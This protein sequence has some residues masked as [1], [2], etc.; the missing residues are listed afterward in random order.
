[1][2]FCADAGGDGATLPRRGYKFIAPVEKPLSQ[3]GK[4]PDPTHRQETQ[5]GKELLKRRAVAAA[6]AVLLLGGVGGAFHY[7]QPRLPTVTN[8]VRITNDGKAKITTNSPATDGVRLY[9]VEGEP[10]TTG[11]G[12]A[13]VSATGGE[14]TWIAT[15]LRQPLAISAMSPDH[16]ELLL[17]NG[18]GTAGPDAVIEFWMQPLPAGAAHRFANIKMSAADWVPDGIHIVYAVG[19]SIM[20][21]NKDGSGPH[22]MAEVPG[23]PRAFRFSPDGRRIRFYIIQEKAESSSLWEMDASERTFIRFF[24]IGKSRHTSAAETGR[25]TAITIIF[26]PVTGTRRPSGF[27]RSAVPSFTEAECVLRV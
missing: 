13:Q 3:D 6:V 25:R 7:S 15:T 18:V 5:R 24:R 26:R 11:S 22:R 14:T 23:V 20:I 12:I 17:P 4:E 8:V 10:W 21:A 9:F 16:T 2:D 27:C 19:H 1:V